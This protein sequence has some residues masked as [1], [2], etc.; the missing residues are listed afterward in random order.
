M[1]NMLIRALT[2]VLYIALLVGGMLGGSTTFALL[3]PCGSSPA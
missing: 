3:V 1:N 2:G